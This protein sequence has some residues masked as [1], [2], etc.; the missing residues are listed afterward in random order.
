MPSQ[1]LAQ[2]DCKSGV[3]GNGFVCPA[4]GE[5]AQVAAD[6]PGVHRRCIGV[7]PQR[8]R[9]L[10]VTP[11]CHAQPKG[12]PVVGQRKPP[13]LVRAG[14]RRLAGTL[15]GHGDSGRVAGSLAGRL[16]HDGHVTLCAAGGGRQHHERV[17]HRLP[18]RRRHRRHHRRRR[19]WRPLSCMCAGR[20]RRN[21]CQSRSC[22]R[23]TGSL[24]RTDPDT[25]S[26]RDRCTCPR[27]LLAPARPRWCTY[28]RTECPSWGLRHVPGVARAS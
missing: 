6:F 28:S 25:H 27:N 19:Y 1:V 8:F 26:C 9:G 13:E 11:L 18:H 3:V 16:D 4:N 10:A 20:S 14:I 12:P 23:S 2:M 24:A 22:T 15:F 21:P 7:E 5:T 17:G